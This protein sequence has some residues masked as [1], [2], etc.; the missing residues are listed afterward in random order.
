[1][2]QYLLSGLLML[3]VP[4]LPVF[5]KL[6]IEENIESA[7]LDQ[8][9]VTEVETTRGTPLILSNRK[10]VQSGKCNSVPSLQVVK[11]FT[12]AQQS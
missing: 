7:K 2:N 6:C 12:N 9:C 4:L 1:M 11:Q 5:A 8:A 10:A 3:S